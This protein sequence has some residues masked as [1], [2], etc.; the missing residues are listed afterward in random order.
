VKSVHKHKYA[1]NEYFIVENF[2][3]EQVELTNKQAC[4]WLSLLE[5]IYL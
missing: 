2:N 3:V 4:Q 1:E 5:H